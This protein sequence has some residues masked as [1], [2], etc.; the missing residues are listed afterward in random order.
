M[1]TF[2][3]ILFLLIFY[4]LHLLFSLF[5]IFMFLDSTWWHLL[6]SFHFIIFKFCCIFL[7]YLFWSILV[8]IITHLPWIKYE[9]KILFSSSKH[10][11]PSCSSLPSYLHFPLFDAHLLLPFFILITFNTFT[12]T[13]TVVFSSWP[14]N[15]MDLYEPLFHWAYNYRWLSCRDSWLEKSKR[16]G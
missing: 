14:L 6:F 16:K 12:L 3:S 9:N 10:S 4:F 1:E 5:F 15:F 2:S 11:V 7:F 13:F 8:V